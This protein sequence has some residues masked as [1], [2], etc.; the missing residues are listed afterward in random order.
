LIKKST[1]FECF[2]IEVAVFG[3]SLERLRI[4]HL[5]F[6]TIGPVDL[7]LERKE[8]IGLTGPSGAG[9][10]LF[11]RAV[12]DMTPYRGEVYLDGDESR[13]MS[14]PS[15]RKRVGLLPAESSWWYDTVG[16][17][18][19]ALNSKWFPVLGFDQED[20]ARWEISRLSSGERQRLRLDRLSKAV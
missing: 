19:T 14:G 1:L 10:T 20:I 4:K 17:H 5:Y 8:C 9:K 13:S 3:E 6:H 16:E 12:A 7:A 18:F 11:L 15:W 2:F